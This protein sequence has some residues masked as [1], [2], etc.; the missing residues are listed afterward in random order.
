MYGFR[1]TTAE[2]PTVGAL[3]YSVNETGCPPKRSGN[4][5]F[6]TSNLTR[7]GPPW[8]SNVTQRSLRSTRQTRISPSLYCP[9]WRICPH[10]AFERVAPLTVPSG[11]YQPPMAAP[12]R[13][14]DAY[15]R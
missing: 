12:D 7:S 11:A 6:P 4:V 2:E 8:I 3:A 9:S 13:G 1:T 15:A 5:S 14:A 10:L